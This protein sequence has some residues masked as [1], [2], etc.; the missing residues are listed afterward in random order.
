MIPD[1][2][3]HFISVSVDTPKWLQWYSVICSY[4][5]H[6]IL[7]ESPPFRWTFGGDSVEI[8][9]TYYEGRTEWERTYNGEETENERSKNAE[10]TKKDCKCNETWSNDVIIGI[11]TLAIAKQCRI[12]HGITTEKHD[13]M[14]KDT[15]RKASFYVKKHCKYSPY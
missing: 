15:W 9:W 14:F 10:A 4:Q 8:R 13:V 5:L 7:T 2:F 6:H 12:K 3:F 11:L 1:S